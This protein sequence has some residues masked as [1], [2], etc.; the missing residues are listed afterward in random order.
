MSDGALSDEQIRTLAN[1]MGLELAFVDFKSDLLAQPVEYNKGYIVNMSDQYDKNGK[2]NEGTHWVAF[3]IRKYPNGKVA[4]CY[5]D[6]FG[7]VAPK[8]ITEYIQHFTGVHQVPYNLKDVQS[9]MDGICGYYCLAWLYFIE[10]MRPTGDLYQDTDEFINM[11]EDLNK[12]INFK[13]NEFILKHFFRSADPAQR[14][15]V[16]VENHITKGDNE[17]I[18]VDINYR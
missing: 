3:I 6:S 16:S 8:E 12:S 1:K 11:F 13:T 18:P 10:K 9:L 17:H 2:E 14:I 15:P 7:C 4:P 5:F